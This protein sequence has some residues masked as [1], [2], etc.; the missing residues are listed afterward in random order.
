MVIRQV[1]CFPQLIQISVI[2][3]HSVETI[4]L[5]AIKSS[6]AAITPG[7]ALQRVSARIY[8]LHG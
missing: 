5:N 6:H 2:L 3:F 8:H 4:R 1:V 7:A